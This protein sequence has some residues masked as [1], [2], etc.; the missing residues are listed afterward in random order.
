MPGY[1]QSAS[2]LPVS[3]KQRTVL[4]QIVQRHKSQQR[5]VLRA[6]IILYS[7]EGMSIMQV[8]EHLNV[9]R[10]TVSLWRCVWQSQQ[11]HLTLLEVEADHP[12]LSEAILSTLSDAPRCGTPVTYTAQVVAQVVAVSCE[13]PKACGY[14]ISH[15]TPQALREEVIARDIV[16][17]SLVRWVADVCDIKQDLGEK[18]K[19]GILKSMQTRADFLM[20][21]A[22]RVRFVYTPKHAS[23][24]NQIECWFSILVRRLLK[25]ASFTSVQ[26]LQ[27]SLLDFIDFFNKTMA[28]PFK[29]TYTGRPL[30]I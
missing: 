15:W 9:H 5:H 30:N 28:K 19:S 26:N 3:V 12:A 13:D 14:P 18:G 17:E 16:S 10:N 20:D 4:E 1:Y 25:R 8:A 21:E 11:E 27:Q 2:A 24:L 29:W 6:L 22:H 7:S 23:W